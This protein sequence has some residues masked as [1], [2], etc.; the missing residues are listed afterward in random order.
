MLCFC[1][2]VLTVLGFIVLLSFFCVKML[3]EIFRVSSLALLPLLLCGV[4]FL[5]VLVVVVL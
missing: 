5:L 4:W 3:H 1:V 2:A